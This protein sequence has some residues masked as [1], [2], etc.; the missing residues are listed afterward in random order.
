[1]LAPAIEVVGYVAFGVSLFLGIA[2]PDFALLFLLVSIGFGLLLS[3]WATVLEEVSFRRYP[4]F[5]D[6]LLLLWFSV[7]E[8]FGYRQ[9][10]LWFR[11]QSYWKYVRGDLRWG[12]MEREGFERDA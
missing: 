11:L 8:A 7:I 6:F 1:M 5:R 4:A 9:I 3:L 10:T 12:A 2:D